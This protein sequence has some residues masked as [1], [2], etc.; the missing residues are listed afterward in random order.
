MCE[1]AHRRRPEVLSD[2]GYALSESGDYTVASRCS[3]RRSLRRG[4][5]GAEAVSARALIELSY[6]RSHVD[7]SLGAAEMRAVAEQAIAVFDRLGDEGGLSRAW[8]HI[9]LVEW[10]RSDS[11]AMDQALQRALTHAER[12]GDRRDQSRI[13]TDLARTTVVGPRP[14]REGI[15]R[16]HELLAR[17]EGDIAATAFTEAMLAVLEAMDG[18]FDAARAR[19]RASKRRLG[20]VG[21]SVVAAVIQMYYGYIELLAD[22]PEKAEPELAAACIAFDQLGS[23]ATSVPPRD[24]LPACTTPSLI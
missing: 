10:I 17:A 12:A 1:A 18:H 13:L 3:S 6:Q 7:A 8:L 24:W 15:R 4:S 9:A 19:W 21:L 11:V 22:C 20:D 16:C 2:L 14:V 23:G 5:P